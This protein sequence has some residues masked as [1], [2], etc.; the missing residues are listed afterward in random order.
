MKRRIKTERWA[1][2]YSQVQMD[3]RDIMNVVG[4]MVDQW[5]PIH[6]CLI[7]ESKGEYELFLLT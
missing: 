2:I 4:H 3:S 5:A 1:E 7:E 6:R